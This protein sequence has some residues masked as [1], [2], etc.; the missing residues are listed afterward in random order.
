MRN[1]TVK[2]K[3]ILLTALGRLFH[4]PQALVEM[5]LNYDCDRTSLGNIYERFMN[6]V[7][8]LATT[9]YTTS[10]TTS[11]SAELI[12]S[13]NAPGLSG[14]NSSSLSGLTSPL[15]ITSMPP[16][17]S[18]TSMLQGMADSTFY[19]H[20]AVEGQLKRQSLECLVATL[21]SL[22][23]WAGKGAVQ[24]VAPL[25]ADQLNSANREN[26]H[27]R[28]PSIQQTFSQS[29]PDADDSYSTEG[30]LASS[31]GANEGNAAI[32]PTLAMASHDSIHDDPRMFETAKHQKTTLLEGIRQFNFKPKRGIKF[33]I[34][35]GFI[36]NSKPKEIA[37]F[38]LTADGLS[39]AMIG[40]YLGEG[41]V[42][43]VSCCVTQMGSCLE[44]VVFPSQ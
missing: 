30:V 1:S 34:S 13:P 28:R 9:Q 32:S 42:G 24:S 35:N 4:D 12:G 2:Q 37:R 5:Y 44:P 16:S 29:L 7:S 36:R 14:T 27:V 8:K 10:T 22:V 25:L 17:L 41:S 26:H 20:Q 40:E 15:G 39:K 18:T 19:S 6:I 3:S 31:I 11:Q 23:V 33:L 21:K 38:L 43:S